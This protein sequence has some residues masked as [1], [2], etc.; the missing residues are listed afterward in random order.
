MLFYSKLLKQNEIITIIIYNGK[1]NVQSYIYVLK[2]KRNEI[3]IIHVY[4]RIRF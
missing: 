4:G 2:K 1:L 3:Y